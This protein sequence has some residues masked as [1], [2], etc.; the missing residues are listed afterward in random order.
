MKVKQS[1]WSSNT[2]TTYSLLSDY[3]KQTLLKL[4]KLTISCSPKEKIVRKSTFKK[5]FSST[6]QSNKDTTIHATRRKSYTDLSSLINDQRN[7]ACH[8]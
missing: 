3:Q 2:Y 1:H 8:P 7:S 6:K 4:L 5:T